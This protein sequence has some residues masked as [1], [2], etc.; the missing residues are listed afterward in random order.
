LPSHTY[1]GLLLTPDS[2]PSLTPIGAAP[3]NPPPRP[4]EPARGRAS[5]DRKSMD[6]TADN[7]TEQTPVDSASVAL[8]SSRSPRAL[9]DGATGAS[10]LTSIV[11]GH[12]RQPQSQ[13][14]LAVAIDLACRLSAHLHVVHA[15]D[16]SDAPIDP[17]DADWEAQTKRALATERDEIAASLRGH[18]TG[19]SYRVGHGDPARLLADTA[20]E[21]EALMII[22]GSRG[23]GLRA[24]VGRL[25]SAPV[26]HRLIQHAKQPVLVV[27]VGASGSSLPGQQKS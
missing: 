12:D 24:S 10:A 21:S 25:G 19:W 17:D 26:S 1:E 27:R 23:E 8:G 20:D 15:I 13:A 4:T 2:A 18:A 3:W 9:V 14:A 6:E 16:L 5:Y 7:G 11:L 22:I